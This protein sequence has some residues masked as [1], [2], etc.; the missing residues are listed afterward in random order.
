MAKRDPFRVGIIIGPNGLHSL[1][2]T[3]GD[4]D[5]GCDFLKSARPLITEFVSRFQSAYATWTSEKN[6]S[7]SE[8]L[9]K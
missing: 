5:Q 1:G 2:V 6:V 7:F 9:R 8:D 4:W 3:H